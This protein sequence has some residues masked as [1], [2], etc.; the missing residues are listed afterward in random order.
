MCKWNLQKINYSIIL[1]PHYIVLLLYIYVYIQGLRE[2]PVLKV[3]KVLPEKPLLLRV[4]PTMCCIFLSWKLP[5]SEHSLAFC[6]QH[7]ILC[8]RVEMVAWK[9]LCY[10]TRD[11]PT[12]RGNSVS[13]PSIISFWAVSHLSL[14]RNFNWKTR[15][16]E[17]QSAITND[18]CSLPPDISYLSTIF[19]VCPFCHRNSLNQFFY[20][21][22]NWF[23]SFLDT[24]TCLKVKLHLV[25]LLLFACFDLFSVDNLITQRNAES[26]RWQFGCCTGTILPQNHCPRKVGNNIFRIPISNVVAENSQIWQVII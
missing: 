12:P 11:K 3:Q 5:S 8:N 1:H 10:L 23:Y 24:S 6:V 21:P 18:S 16:L 9:G 26:R 22:S 13:S 4:S 25:T 20:W 19:L 15:R 7:L 17:N 14:R 2:Q